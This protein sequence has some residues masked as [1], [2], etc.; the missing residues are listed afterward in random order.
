MI[1]I[2]MMMMI[3]IMKMIMIMLL[4]HVEL[5]LSPLGEAGG[6]CRTSLS[7]TRHDNN[8]DDDNDDL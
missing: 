3:Q 7:R 8:F 5:S 2:L 6:R 1:I 4:Y